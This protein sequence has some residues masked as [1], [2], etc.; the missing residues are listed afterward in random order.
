MSAATHLFPPT[1]P[2]PP[3]A[4]A[5]GGTGGQPPLRRFTIEEY[6]RLI[7]VGILTEDDNVELLEGLI[8]HKMPRNPPHDVALSKTDRVLREALPAGWFTRNQM[9]ITTPDSEPEPDITVVPGVEDDYLA[10][11]PVP[12]DIGVVIEVSDT[13]IEPDR[14]TK[15]PLYARARI[16]VYWIVNIPDRRVE[17]YTDPSGA[18]ATPGYATLT[19]YGE[20]D[21]VPV[22][23]RGREVGRVPVVGLL[24][25][26]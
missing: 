10:S 18:T 3:V 25:R 14:T 8:V 7:E 11:H 17:V 16:P 13:T 21:A 2:G 12:T 23:I 15:G 22:V 19:T 20:A 1:P 9:A 24:P 6:H 5:A 4:P 26:V